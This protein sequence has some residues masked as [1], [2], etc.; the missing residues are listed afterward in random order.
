MRV[1]ALVL[2]SCLAV[3]CTTPIW[4]GMQAP[5]FVVA[6]NGGGFTYP[7]T[8]VVDAPFLIAG[9][10]ASDLH[11]TGGVFHGDCF[12]DS[13]FCA[14]DI[15]DTIRWTVSGNLVDIESKGQVSNW[16]AGCKGEG[17][18]RTTT[19][20]P[21]GSTDVADL[22]SELALL[23]WSQP[24]PSRGRMRLSYVLP[25]PGPVFLELYDPMGRSVARLVDRVESAGM[26]TVVWN[27]AASG[28]GSMRGIYFARL[29]FAGQ[30]RITRIVIY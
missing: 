27:D 28:S 22:G 12:C 10:G 30:T 11:N 3:P 19:I 7:W 25:A 2:M 9:L 4:A 23:L 18:S 24:N 13:V 29:A 16:L 14:A 6:A 26:H 8:F 21:P 5:D 15:G 20:L 1:G 17:G